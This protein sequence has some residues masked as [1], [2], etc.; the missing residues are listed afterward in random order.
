MRSAKSVAAPA[1][2]SVVCDQ[3]IRLIQLMKRQMFLLPSEKQRAVQGFRIQRLQ[4]AVSVIQSHEG[5][6][7][8]MDQLRGLPGVGKG[9]LRRVAE[10]LSTGRLAEVQELE[11]VVHAASA[12]VPKVEA[13]MQLV[14]IGRSLAW[15]L[16]QE[17]NVSSI[18]DLRRLAERGELPARVVLGLKY[19]RT[20]QTD[21]PR[22][23]VT[24][25]VRRIATIVADKTTIVT[26]CG[27]YRRGKATS[28]DIDLLICDSRLSTRKD[29]E[30]SSRLKSIVGRLTDAGVIVDHLTPGA[31]TTKYMGFMAG[32][33]DRV[34]RI[35]VRLVAT[36]SY[37]PALLYFTGPWELNIRMR[38]RA[39]RLGYKLNEYD[40]TRVG[41]GTVVPVTSERE[42]FSKLDMPYVR[43]TDR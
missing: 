5:D 10:I 29:V 27:S 36:Q 38:R 37:I 22:H 2:K 31:V 15:K 3:L 14:G 13:L 34:Y 43:P 20:L 11:A 39:Q 9:T 33:G 4:Q 23:Q 32:E 1:K 19:L 42:L 35:D 17:H 25:A 16:V 41:D 21:I 28:S 8:S 6:L 7:S 26:P 18:G 12:L 40:L 30:A 24:M